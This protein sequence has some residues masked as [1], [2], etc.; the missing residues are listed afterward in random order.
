MLP[1]VTGHDLGCP[2]EPGD[3]PL[4]GAMFQV[5]SSHVEAWREDPSSE[6]RTVLLTRVGDDSL[7]FALGAPVAE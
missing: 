2:T 1:T 4:D 6:F 7:R 3:Y 5:G